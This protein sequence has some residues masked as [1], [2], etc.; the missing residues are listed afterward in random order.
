MKITYRSWIIEVNVL[1]SKYY[2][3]RTEVEILKL[4][5]SGYSNELVEIIEV[6]VLE[7]MYR[8]QQ[9]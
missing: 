8:N 2:N 6:N 4:L 5:K 1:K 7:F 9:I 3:Q